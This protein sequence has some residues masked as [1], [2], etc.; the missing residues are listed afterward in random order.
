MNTQK[1]LGLDIDNTIMH[2]HMPKKDY[3]ISDTYSSGG[4]SYMSPIGAELFKHLLRRFPESVMINSARS[5]D[6]VQRL[7]VFDTTPLPKFVACG[8]GSQLYINGVLDQ[9]YS[10]FVKGKA[11]MF[12]QQLDT[13]CRDIPN[14]SKYILVDNA[15]TV[16]LSAGSCDSTI[17][18]ILFKF[19]TRNVSVFFEGHKI[20]LYTDDCGKLTA[21]EYVQQKLGLL[22]YAYAG[23][24]LLDYGC[25]ALADASCVPWGSWLTANRYDHLYDSVITTNRF[26]SASEELLRWAIEYLEQEG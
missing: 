6:Q 23:D 10:N 5:F 7:E 4:H 22:G 15:T 3:I 11:D 19:P 14:L 21:Q 12:R 13:A 24:S 9:D 26:Q 25:I 18:Q 16:V 2:S 8:N 1:L 20:Y 17:R